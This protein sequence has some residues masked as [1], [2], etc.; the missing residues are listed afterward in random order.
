[1]GQ[2]I[3]KLP[4]NEHCCILPM[5]E[6]RDPCY[7]GDSARTEVYFFASLYNVWETTGIEKFY[8]ET[9]LMRPVCKW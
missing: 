5:S 6:L 3:V 9:F 8:S 1:M 2:A 7:G 4:F